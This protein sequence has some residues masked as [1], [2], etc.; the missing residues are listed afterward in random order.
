MQRRLIPALLL[1]AC[2]L[3]CA[4]RGGKVVVLGDS[5][6][7][8]LELGLQELFRDLGGVDVVVEGAAK[9]GTQASYWAS[10]EGREHIRAKIVTE[11]NTD[12]DVV[13]LMMGWWD[14]LASVV[15]ARDSQA[16]IYQL[17]ADVA[18]IGHFINWLVQGQNAGDPELRIVF[19]GYPIL[20]TEDGRVWHGIFERLA[21][22]GTD[23]GAGDDCYL[24]N[25]SLYN[26]QGVLQRHFGIPADPASQLPRICAYNPRDS[27]PH[28]DRPGPEAAYEPGPGLD[29]LHLNREG[30]LVLA[31]AV[32]RD[33]LQPL[34]GG[35]MLPEEHADWEDDLDRD[36]IC[37]DE[38][39][40]D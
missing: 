39:R 27:Y 32:Y 3:G 34:L 33:V 5:Q 36:S 24:E 15:Y 26:A 29:G 8:R 4:E 19:V 9:G 31:K 12:V 11:Q 10:P 38:D 40:S 28:L 20:P 37:N 17:Q 16:A 2:T 18:S 30:R 1:L 14:L 25:F 6:A 13:I 22:L 23:E 35:P 21:S 7:V